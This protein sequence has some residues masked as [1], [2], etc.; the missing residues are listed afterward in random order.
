MVSQLGWL[1]CGA[2]CLPLNVLEKFILFIMC[3]AH[4]ILNLVMAY[5]DGILLQARTIAIDSICKLKVILPIQVCEAD[6]RQ[7]KLS[8]CWHTADNSQSIDFLLML[9][10]KHGLLTENSVN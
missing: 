2:L 10:W 4:V 7:C 5:Y 9:K 1:R 6:K 3:R 8:V